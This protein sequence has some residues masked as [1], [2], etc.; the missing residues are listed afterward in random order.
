MA[1]STEQRAQ[2]DRLIDD[3]GRYA[4]LPGLAFE[5]GLF[6]LSFD[7]VEVSVSLEEGGTKLI[8]RSPLDMAGIRTDARFVAAVL[9]ANVT[10]MLHGNGAMGIDEEVGAWVWIDHADPR[11]LTAETLHIRLLEAVKAIRFWRGR[12]PTLIAPEAAK[13]EPAE[14]FHFTIIR[15]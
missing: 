13:A 6:A 2:V 4:G 14:D 12:L 3:Y 15:G 8:L 5:D 9:M 7:D 1:V 11:G 10:S